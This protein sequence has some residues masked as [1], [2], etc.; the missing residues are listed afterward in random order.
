MLKVELL[1]KTNM[2][3]ETKSTLVEKEKEIDQ[4]KRKVAE[5][6]DKIVEMQED[7]EATGDQFAQERNELGE[8]LHTLTSDF[9]SVSA[10]LEMAQKENEHLKT[11]FIKLQTEFVQKKNENE[12][13]RKAIQQNFVELKSKEA[14]LVETKSSHKV[15]SEKYQDLRKKSVEIERKRKDAEGKALELENEVFKFFLYLL[16]CIPEIFFADWVFLQQPFRWSS[17]ST[18][19]YK[20]SMFKSLN[21]NDKVSLCQ[22]MSSR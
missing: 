21:H 10:K 9:K 11:A 13:L 20:L 8:K 2:L 12:E 7:Q 3:S 18:A 5:L 4:E 15:L 1:G 22:F 19:Y 14:E 6:E 16:F 17:A